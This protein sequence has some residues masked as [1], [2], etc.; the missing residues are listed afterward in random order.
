MALQVIYIFLK[1]STTDCQIIARYRPLYPLW[2][3]EMQK[4]VIPIFR[5]LLRATDGTYACALSDQNAP[6]SEDWDAY[7]KHDMSNN[8]VPTEKSKTLIPALKYTARLTEYLKL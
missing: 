5:G 6:V 1:M 7:E 8:Q 2:R 4:R 3:S